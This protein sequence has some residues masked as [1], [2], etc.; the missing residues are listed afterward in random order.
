MTAT[1]VFSQG[2][3]GEKGDRGEQVSWDGDMVPS[4]PYC[5]VPLLRGCRALC[6][7]GGCPVEARSGHTRV[8]LLSHAL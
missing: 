7:A 8:A 4:I 3:R 2:D 1:V 5:V 6:G